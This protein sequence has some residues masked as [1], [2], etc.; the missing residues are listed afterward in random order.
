MADTFKTRSTLLM[1]AK[2]P[3]NQA[4]WDDFADYYAGF[5]RIILCRMSVPPTEH[6]DLK[7]EILLKIWKGLESFDPDSQKARF[8]TW[9]FTVIKN[10]IIQYMRSYSIR[11][12]RHLEVN[13]NGNCEERESCN[14]G[15]LEAIINE[16]WEQYM[17]SRVLDHLR[18]F[19]SGK[20]IDVFLLSAQGKSSQEICH[21][22]NIP[23]NTVYVL[24][25]R[26]KVR[27]MSEL[28][29]LR[30]LIEF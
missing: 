22:L 15:D 10:V 13:N 7:Q 29:T 4:A 5:I 28:K 20:A 18:T 9:L 14:T 17:V 25:N 6:D 1:R 21:E 23:A 27:F 2:D 12:R 19:F 8:R 11:K 16:E 24:R 3:N 30:Q 26:V